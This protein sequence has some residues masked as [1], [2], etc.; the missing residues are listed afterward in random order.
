M[1]SFTIIVDCSDC[2]CGSRWNETVLLI[3]KE[4]KE[5]LICGRGCVE[6]DGLMANNRCISR[7]T[8]IKRFLVS[9]GIASKRQKSK[10]PYLQELNLIS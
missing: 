4:A 8:K 7:S 5:E 6:G 10:R 3:S 9:S 1:K 2:I